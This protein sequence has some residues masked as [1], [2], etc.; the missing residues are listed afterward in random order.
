ML[1]RHARKSGMTFVA[2]ARM[3]AVALSAFALSAFAFSAFVLSTYATPV[4]ATPVYSMLALHIAPQ[5]I[6]VNANVDCSS[7][8]QQVVS[9]TGGELL[10]AAPATQNG[11][12]VCKITVL[13]KSSTG[14]RP[15][16]LSVTVPQ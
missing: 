9:Q 6:Y 3:K 14:Q 8:A 11:Q 5:P 16:K 15:K 2:V 7:S 1:F 10:S 4:H 12:T 13:V